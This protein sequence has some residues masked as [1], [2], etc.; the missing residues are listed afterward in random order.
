MKRR[1]FVAL[2]AAIF[3]LILSIVCLSACTVVNEANNRQQNVKNVVWQSRAND[4]DIYLEFTVLQENSWH[5][6][7][8]E[9]GDEKYEIAVV[10]GLS[11]FSLNVVDYYGKEQEFTYI[12]GAYDILGDRCVELEISNDRIYD[13]QLVGKKIVVDAVDT[14][15]DLYDASLRQEVCWE[16]ADDTMQLYAYQGTRRFCVGSFAYGGSCYQVVLYYN[17]NMSFSIY[18][19]TDGIQQEEVLASGTYASNGYSMQL[20]YEIAESGESVTLQLT[21]RQ[22]NYW[23]HPQELWYPSQ[24]G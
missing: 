22:V 8:I 3:S 13:G 9:Y 4:C 11:H 5:Y 10:W 16:A 17:D 24:N 14:D 7:F 23:E 12:G 19:L 1:L 15:G 20:S 6:G 21:G 18:E 2:L